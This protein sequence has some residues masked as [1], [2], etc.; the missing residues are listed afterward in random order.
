MVAIS[1]PVRFFM[2]SPVA[3]IHVDAR[4]EEAELVL[5][6]RRISSLAVV[7]GSGA[8]VGVLSRFD[9]LRAGRLRARTARGD[10]LLELPDQQVHKVMHRDVVAVRPDAS[11]G[12]AARS[13][14]EHHI[15]RVFVTHGKA[16]LGVLSTKDVMRAVVAARITVPISEF[17]SSPV[18]TIEATDPIGVAT[19]KLAIAQVQG[20]I[21]IDAGWPVGLFSQAEAL[22]SRDLPTETPV[23]EVMSYSM[24]CLAPRTPL[25]RASGMAASTRARRVLVIEHHELRGILTG[26]DLARAVI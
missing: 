9:L 4:L 20:L 12:A 26:I 2:S 17:M 1:S 23:E 14:V 6:A 19:D 16:L 18:L 8:A 3:T 7:D 13:M 15:H 24:L 10:A 22:E 21:V 11:V 25:F 5:S